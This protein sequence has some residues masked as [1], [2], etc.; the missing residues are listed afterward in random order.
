[1]LLHSCLHRPSLSSVLNGNSIYLLYV[2]PRQFVYSLTTAQLNP[3]LVSYV[4]PVDFSG[5]RT[6]IALVD[7]QNFDHKSAILR[8]F[9]KKIGPTPASFSFIFVLFIHK[10]Y[11]I[12]TVGSSGIRTLIIRVEGEH[13]DH[14][15][16]TTTVQNLTSLYL[17]DDWSIIGNSRKLFNLLLHFLLFNLLTFH[18]IRQKNVLYSFVR[19]TNCVCHAAQW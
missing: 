16:T 9:L 2:H 5:I 10:F 15:N 7:G 12:K 4:V 3:L 14:L 13:A 6:E 18:F 11:R 8:Y 1:M 19:T 17:A